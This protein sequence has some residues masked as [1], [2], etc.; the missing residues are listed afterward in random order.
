MYVRIEWVLLFLALLIFNAI[1][2]HAIAVGIGNSLIQAWLLH[3]LLRL[4]SF[5]T[6]HGEAVQ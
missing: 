4:R 5:T 1:T 6:G 2:G 3:P